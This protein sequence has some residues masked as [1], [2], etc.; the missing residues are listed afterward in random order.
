MLGV[1]VDFTVLPLLFIGLLVF[2]LDRMN[3]ANVLTG[4]FAMDIGVDQSTINLGNQLMF[5]NPKPPTFCCKKSV[6]RH[7]LVC[8]TEA[9]G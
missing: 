5:N 9:F 7:V 1:R 2:Q 6:T 4:G 8:L 3:I